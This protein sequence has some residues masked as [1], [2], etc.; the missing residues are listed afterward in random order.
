MPPTESPQGCGRK[1]ASSSFGLL[2]GIPI[3]TH[4]PRRTPGTWW[5]P[6]VSVLGPLLVSGVTT[7]PD[8][9]ARQ[10]LTAAGD[11]GASRSPAHHGACPGAAPAGSPQDGPHLSTWTTHPPLLAQG[12]SGGKVRAASRIAQGGR[13]HRKPPERLKQ[14]FKMAATDNK[15]LVFLISSSTPSCLL[16]AVRRQQEH[17]RTA[18]TK[19]VF[20]HVH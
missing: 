9:L 5:E 8:R 17:L 18:I 3:R 10:G 20:T 16:P 7:S 13:V 4:R 19:P 12:F 11:I 14:N 15:A 6:V 2:N 1:R